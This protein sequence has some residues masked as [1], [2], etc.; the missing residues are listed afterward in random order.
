M[1][2]KLT[3]QNMYHYPVKVILQN[4]AETTINY[5]RTEEI[6]DELGHAYI[7]VPGGGEVNLI[8]IADKK[9]GGLPP[10]TRWG[11]LICY[12][13]EECVFRYS[14]GGEIKV[15]VNDIGQAML[16]GN[17]E[18]QKVRLYGLVIIKKT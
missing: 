1:T 4:G 16:M 3:V 15:F 2:C 18:F 12:Q 14:G 10:D 7:A 5:M 17:G 13:G 9:I 8:D 6:K 11:M